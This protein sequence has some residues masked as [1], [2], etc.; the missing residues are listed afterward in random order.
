MGN[1]YFSIFFRLTWEFLG[2]ESKRGGSVCWPNNKIIDERPAVLHMC[3]QKVTL[4]LLLNFLNEKRKLHVNNQLKLLVSHSPGKYICQWQ[5]DKHIPVLSNQKKLENQMVRKEKTQKKT[6][7]LCSLYP[8]TGVDLYYTG[9]GKSESVRV[10]KMGWNFIW[11]MPGASL[12][13]T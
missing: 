7:F 10:D 2:L 12:I 8:Y 11:K 9:Q 13:L 1:F 4:I 5:P 6:W 3:Y